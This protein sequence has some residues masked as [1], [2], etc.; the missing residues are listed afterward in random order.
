[1]RPVE[2]A[3]VA[4]RDLVR[5][6]DFLI[7]KSERAALAAAKAITEAVKNLGDFPERGRRPPQ[8]GGRREPVVRF[9]HHGYVVRYRVTS[10]WV[11]ITRIFHGRESR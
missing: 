6:E 7:E 2:F 5:L 3:P 8:G 9:G 4:V 1:V 11:L 10:D